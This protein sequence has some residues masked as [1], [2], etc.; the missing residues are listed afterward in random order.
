MKYKLNDIIE[1]R[2][3][4]KAKGKIICSTLKSGYGV[5]LL[6]ENSTYEFIVSESWL[7]D[8]MNYN[9]LGLKEYIPDIIGKRMFIYWVY[10]SEIINS[11]SNEE[12]INEDD[13]G[14]SLL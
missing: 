1:F 13:G 8:Y 2:R 12:S 9:Y 7:N 3:S 5:E 14:L 4:I 11:N 10:E 6:E